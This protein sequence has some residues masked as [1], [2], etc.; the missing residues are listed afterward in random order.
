MLLRDAG[1][2][3]LTWSPPTC[4]GCMAHVRVRRRL[5]AQLLAA[6]SSRTIRRTSS[7]VTGWS[8]RPMWDFKASLIRVWYA[9]TGRPKQRCASSRAWT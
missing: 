5:S 7:C 2:S 4:A 8:M 9:R 1:L 6:S 3:L